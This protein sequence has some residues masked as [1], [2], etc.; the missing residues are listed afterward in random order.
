M[1]WSGK[2]VEQNQQRDSTLYEG[3]RTHS[4][5]LKV[6]IKDLVADTPQRNRSAYYH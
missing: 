6:F 4:K 1:N 5:I 2:L 3:H